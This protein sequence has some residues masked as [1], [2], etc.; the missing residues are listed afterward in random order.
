MHKR[1]K[2]FKDDL[3]ILQDAMKAKIDRDLY[4][5]T[6]ENI[7]LEELLKLLEDEVE[8]LREAVLLEPNENIIKEAADV[9]NFALMIAGNAG[10]ERDEI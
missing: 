4:K 9:A 1:R 3:F 7:P 2:L 6:W 10:R 8:E 5:G